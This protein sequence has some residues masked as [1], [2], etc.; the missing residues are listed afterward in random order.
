MSVVLCPKGHT[1]DI[2][3]GET[4]PKCDRRELSL[5]GIRQQELLAVLDGTARWSIAVGENLETMRGMPDNCVDAVITDPPYGL[6]NFSAELVA[7]VMR[8]WLTT[9][10]A[11]IPK[12]KG[13]MGKAWDAFVP[14]PACWDEVYRVLKPGGHVLAFA[15]PRTYDLMAM[16][17]RLAGFEVRDQIDYIFGTGFPK[18]MNLAKGFDKRRHDREAV[19]EVTA[20]IRERRD[21]VGVTNQQIDDAFGFVGMSG[22][23]TTGASQPAVPTLEQVPVLLELLKATESDLPPRIAELLVTLNKRKGQPGEAW[24][25]A[26]VVGEH[27][28][29]PQAVVSNMLMGSRYSEIK[30]PNSDLAKQWE[31]FGTALKP[32]HEPVVLARKPPTGTT[33]DNVA[34]YGTGALNIDACR[35]PMSAEDEAAINN[36]GGFG[37]ASYLGGGEKSSFAMVAPKNNIDS[38]AHPKGRWP[39]NVVLGHGDDCT[40]SACGPECAVAEMDRQSGVGGSG[41]GVQKISSGTRGQGLWGDGTTGMFAPGSET[42][43]IRDFGDTGGA[44]RFF[45]TAK[46]KRAERDQGCDDLPLRTAAEMTGQKEGAA[47]LDSPRAGAGRTS[48][49][50]NWHPTAKPVDLMAYLVKLVTPPGGVVFEPFLGSGS[51][52]V[53]ALREGFRVIGCELSD[54]YAEIARARMVD[55]EARVHTPEKV[56]DASALPGQL[57]L[58]GS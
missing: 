28:P 30:A 33:L 15:A 49:A 17:I 21:A 5:V 57:K 54:D 3:P 43:G 10:R 41:G 58:F 24:E 8:T 20:W 36:M 19:L 26:E 23:W 22:H 52:A 2:G 11:Y 7:E 13:F 18:S 46:P 9:D 42:T 16:S 45:Y 53:A 1:S 31:G 50:R 37:Q 27:G 56:A 12:G 55:A 6:A 44:S 14:P 29:V 35:L 25:T 40:D 48:G 47:G 34:T 39:A 32:S 38:E 51:T 4:C